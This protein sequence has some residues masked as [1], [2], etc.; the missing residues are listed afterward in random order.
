MMEILNGSSKQLE[1]FLKIIL[2]VKTNAWESL[3]TMLA[4][5]LQ[6]YSRLKCLKSD[7]I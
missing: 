3:T 1:Q 2:S 7:K 4:V 5:M 6:F